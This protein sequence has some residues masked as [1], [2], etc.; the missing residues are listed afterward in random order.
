MLLLTKELY[1]QGE[2]SGDRAGSTTEGIG[3]G[4]G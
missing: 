1:G 2:V 3:R 4:R